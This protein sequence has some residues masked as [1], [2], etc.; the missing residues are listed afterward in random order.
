MK[1][2]NT[3]I[4]FVASVALLGAFATPTLAGKTV[5]EDEEMDKVT[6]AGQPKI[7]KALTVVGDATAV[8]FQVNVF[9]AHI[10]GQEELT[11]LTLNNVFGENQVGNNVNIQAGDT[12]S[13]DQSGEVTQSW[14]SAYAHDAEVVQAGAGGRG[15]DIV[16]L[17]NNA[18]LNKQATGN[19]GDGGDGAVGILW[20]FADEI[21]DAETVV[22]D[23]DAVNAVI[24]IVAGTFDEFAQSGLT[25]LTVNNVFGFNQLGNNTNISAG[26]LGGDPAIAGATTGSATSQSGTVTQY[27]GAPIGYTDAF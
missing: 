17:T 10:G 5:I 16:N 3:L 11:A 6:A 7:A 19:G 26:A 25:A 13:G 24:T 20:A 9:A 27:R 15:G 12:N 14:G 2:V 1:P 21:T 22:G 18:A 4:S 23:A 8:N